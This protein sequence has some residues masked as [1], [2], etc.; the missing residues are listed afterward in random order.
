MVVDYHDFISSGGKLPTTQLFLR[1][2]KV[3]A[4][5]SLGQLNNYHFLHPQTGAS[6]ATLN[7]LRS[8]LA[9]II[10]TNLALD[11]KIKRFFR[12]VQMLR[13]SAPNY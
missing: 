1:G 7:T 2:S 13:P 3:I 11:T 6:Y 4:F 10:P 5:H 8:S 9:F 12:G